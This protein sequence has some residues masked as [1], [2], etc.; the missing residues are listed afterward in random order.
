MSASNITGYSPQL[1]IKQCHQW[2]HLS[3]QLTKV[4]N[5]FGI[6]HN[7][8]WNDYSKSA[9]PFPAI[10]FSLILLVL[11]I[12]HAISYYRYYYRHKEKR[13]LSLE[14]TIKTNTNLDKWKLFILNGFKVFLFLL[15]ICN[16]GLFIG[17]S[18]IKAGAS[19]VK[20]SI[21]SLQSTFNSLVYDGNNL[22]KSGTSMFTKVETS[23]TSCLDT[24]TFTLLNTA[25][26]EY[27]NYVGSYTSLISQVPS[28]CT[29]AKDSLDKFTGLNLDLAVFFFYAG[30][31]VLLIV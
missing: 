28:E 31:W 16:H 5:D 29:K 9:T 24:T 6:F 27:T 15:L 23:G 21:S 26:K 30:V 18:F 7:S 19:N 8:N 20:D 10:L 25:I 4:S 3:P 11:I 17:Q 22:D 14:Q 1:F 2:P 13:S 12:L